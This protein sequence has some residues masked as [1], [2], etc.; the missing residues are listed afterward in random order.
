VPYSDQY[1]PWNYTIDSEKGFMTATGSGVL[2]GAEMMA[3]LSTATRDPRFRSDLRYLID[4][5]AVTDF[6]VSADTLLE[7]ASHPA[8][9]PKMRRAFFV[10]SG[11]LTAVLNFANVGAVGPNEV[12]ADRSQALAWLN[13]GVP[14][15][16]WIQ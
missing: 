11:F 6:R 13:E 16:K 5:H 9:S 1:M 8:F 15:D 4:H 3:G 10:N 12:F 14:P 7:V 2:T